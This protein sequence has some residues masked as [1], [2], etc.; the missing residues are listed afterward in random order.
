MVFVA[1]MGHK[2]S[3]P[4][5]EVARLAREQW[6]QLTTAQLQAAGLSLKA[7]RL[8]ERRGQVFHVHQG[9]YSLGHA[10][11]HPRERAMAAVLAYAPEGRLASHWALWNYDIITRVPRHPPDV[12][13]NPTR[14]KRENITLHRCRSL[15]PDANYGIPSVSPA[16]AILQAAPELSTEQLR[17][18]INQAQILGRASADTIRTHALNARGVATRALLAELP[19]DERGAT[20]SILEDLLDELHRERDLPV[21]LLN[22][23]RHGVECDFSYPSLNL[24]IEADGW[25]THRTRIQFEDDRAK[26]LHLEACGERVLWVTYRQ[27]TAERDLTAD[28]IEAVMRGLTER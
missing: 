16:Q 4:W 9:V 15:E 14:T 13:A 23:I 8:A 11:A 17:R 6:S 19:E 26:R 20:R 1:H 5:S 22:A 12:A 18:V 21:P 3:T 2:G 27:V 28:R 7:I 10:I 24:V 25:D